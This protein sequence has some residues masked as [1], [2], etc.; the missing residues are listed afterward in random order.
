MPLEDLDRLV[1][2]DLRDAAVILQ[3]VEFVQDWLGVVLED[4]E[5]VGDH[6]LQLVGVLPEPLAQGGQEQL[7][8]V[9][10]VTVALIFSTRRPASTPAR[11]RAPSSSRYPRA[12]PGDVDLGVALGVVAEL[13]DPGDRAVPVVV[14]VAVVGQPHHRLQGAQLL[15]LLV[16]EEQAQRVQGYDF[17]DVVLADLVAPV[18]EVGEQVQQLDEVVPGAQLLVLLALLV[19]PRGCAAWAAPCLWT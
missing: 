7:E 10:Q 13:V 6:G 2:G 12:G 14:H 5:D 17:L 11:N 3:A 16:L 9:E 15:H 4:L 1:L 18:A 8:H 19:E